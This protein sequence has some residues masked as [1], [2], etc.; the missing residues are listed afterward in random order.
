M[1]LRLS[2]ILAAIVAKLPRRE[3]DPLLSAPSLA[4]DVWEP[5]PFI[6]RDEL[7][8]AERHRNRPTHAEYRPRHAKLEP[9]QA[10]AIVSTTD[11]F[12]AL[13]ATWPADEYRCTWCENGEHHHCPGCSCSCSLVEVS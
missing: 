8:I 4:R 12:F 3:P 5:W 10:L 1:K 9:T 11:T 6:S 13:A 7:A 2:L